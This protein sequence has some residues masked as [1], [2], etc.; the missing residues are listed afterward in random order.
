MEGSL[1]TI[2]LISGKTVLPPGGVAWHFA[3]W[4]DADE[5]IRTF[6]ER[7]VGRTL[8]QGERFPLELA[9]IH[10]PDNDY[11]PNA[12]AIAAPASFGGD[13]DS[14]FFGYLYDHQ[15]REIGMTRLP[16]LSEAAEGGEISCTEIASRT[17]LELDLTEPEELANAIDKFL[18]YDG[19]PPR[20]HSQPSQETSDNQ[21]PLLTYPAVQ[22]LVGALEVAATMREDGRQLLVRDRVSHRLIGHV[23][24][25]YLLL[26]DE[27]NRAL[28]TELLTAEGVHVAKSIS[29]PAVPLS[30]EWPI[31]AEP[32]LQV[33]PHPE[34]YRFH[35]TSTLARYNPKT[36]K[37]WVEDS[38]LV[39][40]AL[41][42]AARI[43]LEIVEVGLPRKPWTLDDEVSFREL[44][45]YGLRKKL[46]RRREKAVKPMIRKLSDSAHAAG[47]ERL[48]SKGAIESQKFQIMQGALTESANSF[49]LHE[50]F[51]A[52]RTQLFGVHKLEAS[53]Q[54]C[55][56]CGQ[57]GSTFKAA[58]CAEPLAYCHQCLGFAF[59]GV[60]EDRGRAVSALR[61]LGELE[62][63][64]APML[65]GQL[66][67]LHL[68]PAHPATPET[69]DKLLL[70]KFAVK[71][72][73]F[74][75]TLLLEKTGLAEAGLRLSRGTLVRARDGHRCLSLGEK[76]VCDFLHQ[77]EI[78]HDREPPY[79]MDA[80]FNRSGRRRADWILGDGT[81]V[82]LWG[83]PDDPAYAAKM[84]QKRQL[85]VRHNLR[86]FELTV[87]DL[88]RLPVVFA[89]W[90]PPMETETTS[91]IWS[92]VAK[93]VAPAPK[94]NATTAHG[95]NAF[96][97]AARQNRLSR[98]HRAVELQ[99]LGL[100]S[101]E[102]ARRLQVSTESVKE[103]LRDGRFFSN[104]VSD[105]DRLLRAG[106]A[107]TARNRGYTKMQFQSENGLTTAKANEAWKDADV[108][109]PESA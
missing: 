30:L 17:G 78:R 102:I 66:E 54:S 29:E 74:P 16:D 87:R 27:R 99:N 98:C 13:L 92:P 46:E 61:I 107:V 9:L 53:A 101:R 56:L 108:L 18:D 100:S 64:D 35:S 96:N 91:W 60:F 15:L 3:A 49:R 32:N 5:K 36:R 11:N 48:L 1:Y 93:K 57:L 104:P 109:A 88:A 23:V 28:V 45:N 76:A 82:E 71:R 31:T 12:V 14:R 106:A 33:D 67:R 39:G 90:L 52:A 42:Y 63:N 7:T 72:G 44:Q 105:Q 80:D 62:F 24:R 34:V 2:R 26:E 10:R 79:P 85:A 21:L 75:W 68:D 37:L 50:P 81:L 70:L 51:V 47:L 55:R 8:R 43:G 59:M 97:T 25:G 4:N 41:C 103:L 65:E 77:F 84:L 73:K 6:I 22:G 89:K 95:R 20:E 40:P 86:L 19:A 94:A 69:I 38:R 58:I 83:L